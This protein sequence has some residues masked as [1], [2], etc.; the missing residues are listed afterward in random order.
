[1]QLTTLITPALRIGERLFDHWMLPRL[2]VTHCVWEHE[3]ARSHFAF[4]IVVKNRSKTSLRLNAVQVSK[5]IGGGLRH[6]ERLNFFIIGGTRDGVLG[7]CVARMSLGW[8]LTPEEERRFYF[9]FVPPAQWKSGQFAARIEYQE[10]GATDRAG[11][12]PIKAY[13]SPQ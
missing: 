6:Y 9:R 11:N 4:E 10:Q 13:L 3:P 8:S 12:S 1:M 7:P 2:Q 5:P